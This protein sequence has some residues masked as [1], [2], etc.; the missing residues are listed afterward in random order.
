MSTVDS[1]MSVGRVVSNFNTVVNNNGSTVV[2]NVRY[3]EQGN[4][5]SVSEI[6]Y[7]YYNTQGKE[8]N[9]PD[10]NKGIDIIV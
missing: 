1:N 9:Y 7:T 4:R 2:T 3:V 8:F 6:S 10:K 5:T